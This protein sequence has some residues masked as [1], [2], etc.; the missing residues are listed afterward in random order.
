VNP[1]RLGQRVA[2][3]PVLTAEQAARL[4]DVLHL[5]AVGQPGARA[6]VRTLAA[7]LGLR[8]GRDLI[9]VA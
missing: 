3:V 5:A 6:R 8:D 7:S 4:P 2:E 9:A 1:R